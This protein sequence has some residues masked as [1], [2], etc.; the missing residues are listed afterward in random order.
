MVRIKMI[1][2]RRADIFAKA[3][4]GLFSQSAIEILFSDGDDE[5]L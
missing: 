3:I 2:G 1:P 4:R 5:D